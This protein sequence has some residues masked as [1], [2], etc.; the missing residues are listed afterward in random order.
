MES[1]DKFIIWPCFN[2]FLIKNYLFVDKIF[3]LASFLT[4][5]SIINVK[6]PITGAA[7][8]NTIKCLR[9]LCL[10]RPSW[11]KNETKPNAAGPLRKKL[12]I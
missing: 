8:E 10:S 4:D 11:I 6:I 7:I 2:F 1:E 5:L 3:N 9:T 12:N